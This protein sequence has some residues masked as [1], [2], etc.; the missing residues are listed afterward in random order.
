MNTIALV[1]NPNAGK[2]TLFNAL[3]GTQQRIGNWPG[4]TVEKRTGTF[5][6]HGK[7]F[8]IVDLPGLVDLNPSDSQVSVDQQITQQYLAS[9][10]V[11]LI[12]NV[13]DASTLARDLFLTTQLRE[14]NIPVVIVVTKTDSRRGKSR[15]IDVSNLEQ[16]FGCPTLI[17]S[18]NSQR[19]PKKLRH[20][21]QDVSNSSFSALTTIEER[22]RFIDQVIEQCAQIVDSRSKVSTTLD[23]FV[24]NRWLSIPIFL[25]VMYLMFFFAIN[26]G[27]TLIDFFDIFGGVL[28]VQIP[29]QLLEAIHCPSIITTILATGVGGGIQ[30]VL[31]FVPVIG[32][33]FLFQSTLENSGYMSRVSFIFDRPLQKLGL[34]GKALIPLIVGFGCNV[35]S[36]MATRCIERRQDRILTTIMAPFMSCGARLTVY[37]LFVAAF[38]P[39]NQQNIVFVLYLVGILVAVGSAWLV[40]KFLLSND[41]QSL[42]Q[43]LPQYQ[44]PSV[45]T[46]FG[47]SFTQLKG[48]VWRAGRAIVAV[49]VLLNVVSS[50]GTDGT[51]NNENSENSVLS[52]IGKTITPAFAPMGIEEE[53]WPATVGIFT[54][55]FA[56]EVVVGSL[57]A[58]Y[59]PNQDVES[60]TNL[61][62]STQA[63]FL[64]IPVNLSQLGLYVFNPLGFSSTESV[65]A[66]EVSSVHGVH[67]NTIHAMQS[68]FVGRLGAFSYLIFILLYVPCI[69]TIGVMHKELGGFWA[70]FSVVWSVA[71]AYGVAVVCYQLG[72]IEHH[73]WSATLTI[74]LVLLGLVVL[75][76]LLIY[77]GRRGAPEEDRQI[78]V[79]HLD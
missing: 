17:V 22:Y 14:G 33:L 72:Q 61:W 13:I 69:A 53:N 60:T 79:V 64:S 48:F 16:S 3:T 78:A 51:F 47:Q 2:T 31:T 56:K 4:V 36:V 35:P 10:N 8:N 30:L 46:V 26:V 57:D 37:V 50:I 11:D 40:R 54:G 18:M 38:F 68:L 27:S 75:F 45:K 43:E 66:A 71:I 9:S 77:W 28:F 42:I 34:P 63:A 55:F 70:T 44:W 15:D 32:C 23:S 74:S 24:L 39:S 5:T 58:L 20:T 1:G 73:L 62:K 59:S 52:V 6:S 29:T 49:V 25:L 65:E 41:R 19:D 76:R 67:I 21:I 12:I 7:E